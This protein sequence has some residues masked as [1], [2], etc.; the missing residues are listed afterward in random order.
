VIRGVT[1]PDAIVVPDRAV[2]QGPQGPSV[3]VVGANGT[4]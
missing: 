2:S 4:A 3:F 1:L